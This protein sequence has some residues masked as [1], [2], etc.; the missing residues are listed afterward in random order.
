MFNE[1]LDG[2]KHDDG[3]RK[4]CKFFTRLRRPSARSFPQA[5]PRLPPS[6]LLP[7]KQD[8]IEVHQEPGEVNRLRRCRR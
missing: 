4:K 5:V 3:E 1:Q 7:T 6:S 2:N 8:R